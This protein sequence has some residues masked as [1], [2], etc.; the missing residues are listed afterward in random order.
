[1]STAGE[2]RDTMRQDAKW[3][4]PAD[5]RIL[6]CLR[7]HGNL[8]P[9]AVENSGGPAASTAQNRLPE[10]RDYGMVELAFGTVGLYRLTDIGRAYL[11]E[12]LDAST[13]ESVED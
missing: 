7:D 11:N 6:E 10:L 9:Q 8:T 2:A 1:M 13:L 12:E 4:D 3:M 5:N